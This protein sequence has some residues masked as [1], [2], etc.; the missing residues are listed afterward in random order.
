MRI[1]APLLLAT[2]LF[3]AEVQTGPAVGTRIPAFELEDQ[4]GAKRGFDSLRGPNGLML[5]FMRSADW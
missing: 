2:A 4:S 3:A 1:L 5:V